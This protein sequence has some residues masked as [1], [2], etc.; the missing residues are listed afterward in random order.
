MIKIGDLAS[1][2]KS[3]SLEEVQVFSNLSLDINPIHLNFEYAEKTLFKKPIVHGLLSSSLISAVLANKLPGQ[4]SI[5]LSQ[6]LKFLKPLFHNEF[7][8]AFVKVIDINEI[9]KIYTLK[10]WCIKN[11]DILIIEGIAKI[12]K[13]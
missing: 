7:V 11:N 12:L 5:Y 10:T 4:G 9:K 13:K 3:F 1:I 6:E 8:T 2:S